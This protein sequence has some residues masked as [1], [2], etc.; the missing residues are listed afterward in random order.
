[1]ACM[2]SYASQAPV[3][4][5]YDGILCPVRGCEKTFRRQN[6]SCLIVLLFIK[7][8]IN[9]AGDWVGKTDYYIKLKKRIRIQ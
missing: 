2:R 4:N 3:K 8:I 7:I 9:F 1:M 6:F 5:L